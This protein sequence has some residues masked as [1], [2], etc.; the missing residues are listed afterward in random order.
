[1][2]AVEGAKPPPDFTSAPNGADGPTKPPFFL[3]YNLPP[4]GTNCL[5]KFCPGG[6]A[7]AGQGGDLRGQH[8][9]AEGAEKRGDHGAPSPDQG[10][11]QAGQGG[12]DL[13]ESKAGAVRDPEIRGPGGER[14]RPV[15][16]GL[17]GAH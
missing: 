15:P 12:S 3:P 6:D 5:C 4:P 14:R 13:R 1:M 16:G 11:R 9:Q 2:K 17:R 10:G 7:R 8:L